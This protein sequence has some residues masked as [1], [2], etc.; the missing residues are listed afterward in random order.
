[1]TSSQAIW[2]AVVF[3]FVAWLI[4]F[5]VICYVRREWK[6]VNFSPHK[7]IENYETEK[8]ERIE[9]V[10]SFESRLGHYL[11]TSEVVITLASASL[12]FIPR[13]TV[14]NHPE[15]FAF[16]MTLF[17]LCVLFL[18]LFMVTLLYFYED[19]LY[20]P[21]YYTVKK[22]AVVVASGMTG[23]MAFVAAYISIAIQV[24]KAVGDRAIN[25]K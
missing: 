15:W 18:V 8:F 17:G 14:S 16:S 6:Y 7:F 4:V 22:S 25:I 20:F 24:A 13:L 10:H 21:T 11:K 3:T 23:L 12:V 19:S 1:M 2:L 9:E 5:G